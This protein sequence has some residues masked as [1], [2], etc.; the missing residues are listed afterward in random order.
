MQGLPKIGRW[1]RKCKT[2]LLLMRSLR[3]RF[4]LLRTVDLPTLGLLSE[5]V[6]PRRFRRGE[7]VVR[8]GDVGVSMFFVNTGLVAA[9]VGGREVRSGL[10]G[11][12]CSRRCARTFCT[13]A[14]RRGG[15]C[16]PCV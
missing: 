12:T 2:L 6:R 11:Y 4:E 3:R 5:Q 14:G 1:L 15:A 16:L 10:V 9:I 13:A 8:A 7:T